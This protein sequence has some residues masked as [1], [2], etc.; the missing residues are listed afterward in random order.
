MKRSINKNEEI[1]VFVVTPGKASETEGD[2]ITDSEESTD[3]PST[4]PLDST[5]SFKTAELNLDP[6]LTP[7]ESSTEQS[8]IDTFSEYPTTAINE[9]TEDSFSNT[10]PFAISP[11]E[12]SQTSSEETTEILAKYST[13]SS[14]G[15]TAILA[16]ESST[17]SDAESTFTSSDLNLSTV[18]TPTTSTEEQKPDVDKDESDEDH[19]E[20]EV[21]F[22]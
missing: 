2:E 18:S 10:E 21:S 7:L 14:I 3:L 13:V 22:H 1:G 5:E 12:F 9:A 16:T 15:S 11:F 20:D 17:V 4:T 8:Q 6:F 19:K